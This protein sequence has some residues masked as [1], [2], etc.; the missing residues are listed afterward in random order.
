M[1]AIRM[2][3]ATFV[4]TGILYPLGMT[5]IAPLLFPRQAKGSLV[6]VEDKVVGSELIGQRFSSEGYFHARPSAAGTDGYDASASGGSNLGATSKMLRDRVSAEAERLAAQDP[7][8]PGAV[9]V[10]LVAASG[11]G[12]D[13]HLTLEA[14]LW[15]A[16]RVSAARNVPL[17]E[18]RALVHARL[19]P[20]TFRLLGEPRVNVLLLNIDL[21]KRFGRPSGRGG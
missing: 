17:A 19:E 7:S 4:L 21:D 10:E 12:L 9:P 13:P 16:P 18:V 20:R 14:A 15:E 6:V 5:A 11:S 2:T 8:A 3:L 1:T